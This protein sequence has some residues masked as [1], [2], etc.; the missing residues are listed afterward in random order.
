MGDKRKFPFC[1]GDSPNNGQSSTGFGETTAPSDR[2]FSNLRERLVKVHL[3]PD[4]AKLQFLVE[5]HQHSRWLRQAL[6]RSQDN[7]LDFLRTRHLTGRFPENWKT[8]F[9][10]TF[11]GKIIKF[12]L[13]KDSSGRTVLYP[14][15]QVI[16]YS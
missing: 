8:W 15:N 10:V 7:L 11:R 5:I 1:F 13:A 2:Y 16:S 6:C 4:L 3:E 14:P 12:T 9:T